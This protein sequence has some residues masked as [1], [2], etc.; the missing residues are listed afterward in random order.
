MKKSLLFC[1]L[2]LASVSQTFAQVD[3]LLLSNG[4]L[5]V[6]EIKSMDQGVLT[7]ETDY[8]DSDF[9]ITW[10]EIR[11][12]ASQTNFLITLSSGRRFNGKLNS[13]DSANIRIDYY[14]PVR[15]LKLKKEEIAEKETDL[16]EIVPIATVVYL[17]AVD[18]GFWSRLSA[19]FDI[20]WSLTKANNLQQFNIRS[21]L[22]YLADRW[23]AS[24]NLNSI[25][26]TQDE[27]DDIKRTD[28]NASFNYFLPKDWFL[29]YN[30]TYLSNTEQLIRSRVG[31]QIG[32]GK[33]VI[34][35]NKTYFGFQTGIN[36]N[37]ESYFDDTPSRNSGEALIGTQLNLYDIGDLNLLTTLTA[38]P[39][40]TESGRFRTDFSLDVK[41]DFLDDFYIKV[42]T[43]MNYDN[44][45]IEGATKLDYVFQTTV[46]WEL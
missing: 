43:T 7:M 36:L 41:Y 28:G 39:S 46:G 22:G 10:G 11:A 6:G 9:K 4:N 15:V 2:V 25:R 16:T 19:N 17:N 20:G 29:L 12:I 21:G 5:I 1:I 24:A 44:Q 37:T 31:N 13:V 35:T 42:G 38:Y 34:H 33:Y 23:K 8:S 3:S 30:L 27:V 40:L 14:D 45:P 26:S 32:L 18:E